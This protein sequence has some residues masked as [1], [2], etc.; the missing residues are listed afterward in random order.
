M[1]AEGPFPGQGVV[2]EVCPEL[3]STADTTEETSNKQLL[4]IIQ[5]DIGAIEYSKQKF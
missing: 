4:L 1:V 3:F 5:K 2:V